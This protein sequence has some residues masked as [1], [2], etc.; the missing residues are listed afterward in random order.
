[1]KGVAL[2]RKAAD[3]GNAGAE[4]SLAVSYYRGDGVEQNMAVAAE[5]GRKAADQ[6]DAVAQF[7]VGWWFALGNGVKKDLPLGKR[8]LELG[9]AQGD[10][11]AVTLLRELRKCVACGKL[12]VHHMICSRCH[13]RRYCN[14]TCQLRHW[15]SA[16]NPHKLHSGQRRD[17]TGV[18]GVSFSSCYY[19]TA[20][21]AL[22]SSASSTHE[23]SSGDSGGGG[24]TGGG[25]GGH[26]GAPGG[27]GDGGGGAGDE[28]V[29]ANQCM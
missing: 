19:P 16:T 26:G 17:S 12:D 18:G 23:G 4:R 13:N 21:F 24:G 27:G 3:R 9:A 10:Q 15:N 2:I 11:D 6:G 22:L 14:A 29:N 8:Y 25:G 1:V 20:L 7:L 5:W 28:W